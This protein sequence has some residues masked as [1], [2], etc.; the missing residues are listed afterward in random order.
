MPNPFVHLE[1]ATDDVARAKA[2]YANLFGW[3]MT[4]LPMDYTI[5]SAGKGPGGGIFKRPP[6]A[7]AGWSVYVGVADA[8]AALEKAKRLGAIV[9][10][11]RTLI[12]AEFGHYAV[13]RDPTGAVICLHE[14]APMPRK[15]A[16]PARKSRRPA[17]KARRR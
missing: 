6:E 14:A 17:R 1:L 7:P 15:K 12:S 4:D 10:K 5:F 2:F 16:R 3:K 9:L 13:I 11:D 8:A